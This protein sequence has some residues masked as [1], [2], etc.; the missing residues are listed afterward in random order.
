MIQHRANLDLD[1]LRQPIARGVALAGLAGAWAWIAAVSTV[2]QQ[3]PPVETLLAPSVLLL[4]SVASLAAWRLLRPEPRGYLFILGLMDSFLIGYRLFNSADWL[5]FQAVTM[6]IAALVVGIRPSFVLAVAVTLVTVVWR[7]TQVTPRS[8]IPPLGVTWLCAFASWLST[9]NLYTALDWAMQSQSRAWQTTTEVT[10]RREQLRRALDSLRNAHT[11]LSRTLRELEEARR[12]AEEAKQAKSRFVANISHELRTPLNIIIG[13]AEMICTAPEAY[14]LESASVELR[15][16]LLKV[17]RNAEHLLGMIDDVLDLSQIEASRLPVLPKPTDPLRLIRDTVVAASILIRES[18]AELTVNL[19][20]HA[21]VLDLDATRIRQVLLN[22]MNNAARYAPGG[23][24]EVGGWST[25]TEFIT[26][27]RDS[28]PGIPHDRI[29]SIFSEFERIDASA[30]LR[31]KGVGLGLTISKHFVKLHGGRIWVESELGQGS[32]FYFA[33]PLPDR[34]LPRQSVEP[35]QT[36]QSRAGA[37]HHEEGQLLVVSDDHIAVRLLERHLDGL[38][39]LPA[40]STKQAATL[41]SESHPEAVVFAPASAEQVAAALE[42]ARGLARGTSG[43]DVPIVVSAIP[44]ERTAGRKLGV[45]ELL[46]KPIAG[47]ELVAAISRLCAHP[48]QLLVVEDDEDM[49]GLLARVIRRHWPEVQVTAIATAEGA[50]TWLEDH[51]E[52][53]P[54]LILLDLLMPGMGGLAFLDVLQR[55]QRYRSVPV[56]VI[57]ARGP[58]ETAARSA[59]G[60]IHVIRESGLAAAEI[61]R[62]LEMLT[63]ALPPRYTTTQTQDLKDI[64]TTA[65]V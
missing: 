29:E 59:P 22:L 32:C 60:E 17:W 34:R 49:L 10:Q 62:F 3:P 21:P 64:P 4:G 33:L 51:Q 45:A 54:E 25:E 24:I 55:S 13:F 30:G 27:V 41:I 16:D 18:G 19:P 1:E 20:N 50:L 52:T 42:S 7:P 40:S 46:I 47:K 65:P 36:R 56:V 61:V 58:A 12:E 14:G 39:V 5:Y 6:V 28:G 31:Q 37:R 15:E 9:R 44:T 8:L 26:Y 48:R 38:K 35:R 57:T 11:I 43:L 53:L 23:S 2:D 63:K